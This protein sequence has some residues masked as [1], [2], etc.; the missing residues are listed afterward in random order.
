[1]Q[2]HKNITVDYETEWEDQ[3]IFYS[4]NFLQ[5]NLNSK[6]NESDFIENSFMIA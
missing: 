3:D 4:E 5:T 6:I 2:K 1:M